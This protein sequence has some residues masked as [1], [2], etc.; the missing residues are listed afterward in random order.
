MGGM[1]SM[2]MMGMGGTMGA[3]NSGESMFWA[4]LRASAVGQFP[5]QLLLLIPADLLQQALVPHGHLADIAQR[6]Q[7]RIDLGGEV[8]P[9]F[10]QVSMTGPV[11][12]NAM[13]AY[14]LQERAAQYSAGLASK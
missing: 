9:N 5:G 12:A 8:P 6:C 4:A 11:M 1:G 14:F 13:A 10:L 7:I 2:G 3:A